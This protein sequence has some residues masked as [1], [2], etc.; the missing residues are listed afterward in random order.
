M[1]VVPI[2]VCDDAVVRRTLVLIAFTVTFVFVV[3]IFQRILLF[4]RFSV[5]TNRVNCVKPVQGSDKSRDPPIS[6]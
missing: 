1:R 4:W 3:A 2:G 5:Y 6:Q